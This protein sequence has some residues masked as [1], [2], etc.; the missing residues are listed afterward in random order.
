M[1]FDQKEFSAP[2]VANLIKDALIS[3]RRAF[4]LS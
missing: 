3:F 2:Q 4:N 1:I